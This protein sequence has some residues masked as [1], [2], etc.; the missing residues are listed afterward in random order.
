MK[1]K[2][3]YSR[4]PSDTTEI[5]KTHIT[6]LF[7]EAKKTD[8][9]R[10]QDRYV[11]LARKIAMKFRISIPSEYKRRFCPHCYR[12]MIPGKNLRVRVHEHRVIYYCLECKKFWRKPL[13]L[14]RPAN[15]HKSTK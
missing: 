1:Q 9:K 15:T 7:E 6:S 8:D 4:K 11:E 10:L 12:Y 13:K 3:S 2:R 14:K 5:A